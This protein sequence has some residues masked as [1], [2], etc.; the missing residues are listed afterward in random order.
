MGVYEVKLSVSDESGRIGSKTLLVEIT[1]QT[2]PEITFLNDEPLVRLIG[3]EFS[4][5]PNIV[6]VSDN[7]DGDLT[8]EV[9]II[10]EEDLDPSKTTPQYITLVDTAGNMPLPSLKFCSKNRAFRSMVLQ[11]MAT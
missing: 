4:L 6:A 10:D 7:L 8:S 11:L 3:T 5:P 1:D 2:P 9:L